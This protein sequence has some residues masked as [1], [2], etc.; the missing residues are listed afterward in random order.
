MGHIR[1]GRL[2]K[3]RS[4]NQVCELLSS[5]STDVRNIAVSIAKAARNGLL[6]DDNQ[7]SIFLTLKYLIQLVHASTIDDFSS[8]LESISVQIDP[9]ESGM[10][11]LGRILESLKQS[12]RETERSSYLNT[13]A[14]TSFQE[15][16]AKT[17]QQ[18][19][20]TLFGCSID[21]VKSAFRQYS[22]RNKFGQIARELFSAYITRIFQSIIDRTISEHVGS[23]RTFI[24]VN[25]VIEF[26]NA[27]KTYC[28]DVSKI[29]EDFSGGWYS[30]H[31]W[32]GTLTDDEIKRFSSFA[33]KKLLSEIGS[34]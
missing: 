25:H 5:S 9:E 27:L 22:S 19:A 31:Q 21:D 1:L 28:W 33:L 13:I 34:Q 12:I 26:Q 8:A 7:K 32:E 29:V 10:V 20:Q 4:W 14:A 17:V 11:V 24:D 2:P 18:H 16:L 30:K 3:R 23:D 15:T 6:E